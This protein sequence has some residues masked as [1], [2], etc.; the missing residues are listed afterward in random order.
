[1]KKK[2][3]EILVSF[4]YWFSKNTCFSEVDYVTDRNHKNT[5]Q[6]SVTVLRNL[7]AEMTH[8]FTEKYQN[9]T[10]CTPFYVQRK[11]SNRFTLKS[12]KLA[13]FPPPA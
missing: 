11:T 3:M 7:R 12:N 8:S 13:I 5:M 9:C 10:L 1:M 4:H 2:T 6:G